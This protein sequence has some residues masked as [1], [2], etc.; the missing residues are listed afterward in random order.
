MTR[1]VL[2]GA[3]NLA[4]GLPSVMRRLTA[5]LPRPLEIFAAFGHGRSY[6]GWSR[7]LFRG[8]PGID[9]CQLWDD[10]AKDAASSAATLAL[11]TDVGNDLLYG[12]EPAVIARRIEECLARLAGHGSQTVITRLPLAS[13]ERLS[14]LRFYATRT[15]FFPRTKGSWP[16]MMEHA[17]ELD[18]MLIAMAARFSARLIDQQREWYGFDPIHIRRR[19]RDEAWQTVFSGWPSYGTHSNGLNGAANRLTFTD[20]LR[21]RL[22]PPAERRLFG[23]SQRRAQPA[24]ILND[25]AL[26]L[27]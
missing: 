26:H 9:R 14:A 20:G 27:Y 4:L 2:L 11:I 19:A 21:L 13:I 16:A 23:R 18:Q 1:V 22:A 3:S 12:C 15:I 17:R 6:C 10:L 7:V 5:G 8:L 24:F 25:V